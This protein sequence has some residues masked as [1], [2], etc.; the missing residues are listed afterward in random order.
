M[1]ESKGPPTLEVIVVDANGATK[2]PMGPPNTTF[3]MLKIRLSF[4]IGK[5]CTKSPL[6][7]ST[8]CAGVAEARGTL[9]NEKTT[10]WPPP[11]ADTFCVSDS[12]TVSEKA[13]VDQLAKQ[14][15]H[16]KTIDKTLKRKSM[17]IDILDV[18]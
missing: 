17:M 9:V 15:T 4:A 11:L 7:L 16:V 14:K 10:L 18:I 12:S 8:N 2:V 1:T 6:A 5:V 3:S 13:L